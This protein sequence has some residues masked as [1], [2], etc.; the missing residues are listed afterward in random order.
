MAFCSRIESHR[1][2]GFVANTLHTHDI[3]KGFTLLTADH[4]DLPTL[5]WP[6]PT[7]W[8]GSTRFNTT[9]MPTKMK[10]GPIYLL[11]GHILMC[12][13]LAKSSFITISFLRRISLFFQTD[14]G[15]HQ[16]TDVKW[17]QSTSNYLRKFYR[18]QLCISI[19]QLWTS[20]IN[21]VIHNPI[22]LP[23]IFIIMLKIIHENS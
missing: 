17:K 19:I 9:S 12:D 1:L 6:N 3:M 23:W 8:F 21:M 22:M 11:Q 2:T 20:I 13:V 16:T 18:F 7:T 4:I 10:S 5:R 14:T 15:I